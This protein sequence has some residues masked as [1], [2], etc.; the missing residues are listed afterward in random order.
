MYYSLSCRNNALSLS[1]FFSVRLL[2]FVKEISVMPIKYY[3]I[4]TQV[5]YIC[6]VCVG[7][8]HIQVLFTF[9]NI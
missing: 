5:Y 2:S 3:F 7:C 6:N 1:A 4:L 8:A 9:C